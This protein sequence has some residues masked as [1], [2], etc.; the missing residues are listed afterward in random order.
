MR[1]DENVQMRKQ[2]PKVRELEASPKA[3]SRHVVNDSWCRVYATLTD[4][5]LLIVAAFCGVGLLV[6]LSLIFRFPNVVAAVGEY[7]QF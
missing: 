3:K 4:P 7:N 2:Q 6:M 1:T 5:D